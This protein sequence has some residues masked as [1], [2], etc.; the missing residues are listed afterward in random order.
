MKQNYVQLPHYSMRILESGERT[1]STT[2]STVLRLL[3]NVCAFRETAPLVTSNP[4]GLL[5]RIVMSLV[6]EDKAVAEKAIRVVRLLSR[7][8]GSAKVSWSLC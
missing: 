2:K 5:D 7:S 6:H 4:I 8:G 3:G 1:D